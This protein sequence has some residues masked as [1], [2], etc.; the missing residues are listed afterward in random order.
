MARRQF[1]ATYPATL[2]EV[3]AALSTTLAFR[4]WI[5]SD[6]PPLAG[7]RYRYQTGSVQRAGRVV[8][9]IRPCGLTLDEVLHD[10]PCR[11]RL[12]MRWRI[13]PVLAG[14]A[15]RLDARYRLNH[16]ASVR[17][18]HWDRRL[19]LHFGNQL[20]FLGVN[21]RLYDRNNS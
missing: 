13:E 16:A 2:C 14:S 7:L 19:Q 9:V 10:P 12:F 3:F 21:L 20:R 11:V 6:A 15:V 5:S 4:R 18:R 8:E 17:F 1:R